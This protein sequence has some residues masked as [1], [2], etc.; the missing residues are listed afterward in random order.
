MVAACSRQP[1]Q[2]QAGQTAQ[3]ATMPPA[4]GPRLFVSNEIEGTVSVI[5]IGTRQVVYTI[6]VGKRPRGIRTS[7]DGR[8]VYVALSGSP[9]GGPNVDESK[10][11]PPDRRFDGIGVIDVATGALT[12]V[13]QGGTDP[14]QFAVSADGTRLF[15]A[16]EDAGLTTVL[17]VRDGAILRKVPVGGEPE[18]VDL[19]P[20][21]A[22]VYVTSEN[23]NQ[24]FAIDAERL[25][26][27]KVIDVGPRPRSTGFLPNRPRAYVS[28][29][30]GAAVTVVDTSR[31]EVVETIKLASD[32]L[33][34]MGIVAAPD[35][36]LVYVTTGRGRTLEVIDPTTNT[37]RG[38]VE[39]GER[40]WGLAVATDGRMVFTANGTSNDVSFIDVGS[41]SVVARVPVGERPWGVA[42]VP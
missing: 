18:G 28:A 15:I 9:I 24:V 35:G 34:P 38:S 27:I 14:E 31:H 41:M 8:T 1:Q 40:P 2:E 19:S 10:L 6:P 32:A 26:V 22:F 20:D 30:N 39:V 17:D 29:E 42:L 16:N 4:Q 12:K 36:S 33:R 11:P 7:P 3:P 37:V 21:G 23:D 25:E 5:D 13:L